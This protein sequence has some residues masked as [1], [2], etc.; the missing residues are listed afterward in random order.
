MAWQRIDHQP[1]SLANG[2]LRATRPFISSNQLRT[3]S[4]IVAW[5]AW[6]GEDLVQAAEQVESPPT[7]QLWLVD[8]PAPTPAEHNVSP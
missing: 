4:G 3:G 6:S 7:A 2:S 8:R 5:A 1:V